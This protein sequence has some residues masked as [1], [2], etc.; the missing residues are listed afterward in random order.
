MG[1][2]QIVTY[3][4]VFAGD[5]A[6]L[7]YAWIA[8]FFEIEPHDR[9]L[10]DDPGALIIAPGGQIFF[11]VE[12][13]KALGTVAL[14]DDGDMFELAKMAVAPEAQGRRIGSLLMEA[15]ISYAK[16]AG[17][18]AIYLDS[19]TKLDAAIHL[20]RKFGFKEAELEHASPYARVNIRMRLALTPFNH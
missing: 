9:E 14:I 3:D 2:L 12:D 19:N 13:G 20:Y 1:E 10:L 15:C 4:P 18:A 6:R 17:K 16:E 7:N 11:A 8:L 5:F